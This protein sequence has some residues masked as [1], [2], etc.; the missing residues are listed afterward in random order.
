MTHN[1]I[2]AT[3]SESFTVWRNVVSDYSAD[4]TGTND[5]SAAINNAISGK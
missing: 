1:G 3:I 2:A 5:A 4:N